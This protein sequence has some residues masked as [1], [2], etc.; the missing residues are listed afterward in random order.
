MRLAASKAPNYRR[1]LLSKW[2]ASRVQASCK[3]HARCVQASGICVQA[4][5][6]RRAGTMGFWLFLILEH[7]P[8]YN[9]Y[10]IKSPNMEKSGV[11]SVL[12]EAA[13]LGTSFRILP[14][15]AQLL[16]ASL[17]FYHAVC[18]PLGEGM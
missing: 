5:L 8:K 10:N 1:F 17:E 9:Y 3:H 13:P 6:W 18:Q 2:C 16:A 7:P 4:K 14:K 12:G 11:D 15:L